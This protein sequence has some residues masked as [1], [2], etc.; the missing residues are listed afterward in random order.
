MI[1]L[2]YF[3]LPAALLV[4]GNSDKLVNCVTE[5]NKESAEVK[6]C[7]RDPLL[8]GAI[9]KLLKTYNGW[10]EVEYKVGAW[11]RSQYIKPLT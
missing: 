7:N 10:T 9:V 3:L 4:S 2:N 5:T 1:A 8:K 6:E 11:I